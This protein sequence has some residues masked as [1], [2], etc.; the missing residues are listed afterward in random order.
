MNTK[1]LSPAFVTS[2][3]GIFLG[4]ILLSTS[5]T[6]VSVLGWILLLAGLGLN[7]FSTMVAIQS[8]KGGPLPTV[9]TRELNHERTAG[10]K[11]EP[12]DLQAKPA[13][14]TEPETDAQPI[15]AAPENAEPVFKSRPRARNR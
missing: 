9:I 4:A 13:E 15:I 2:L 10:E 3:A 11:T 6:I 5:S 14:D 1:D 12:E 8:A 7:I